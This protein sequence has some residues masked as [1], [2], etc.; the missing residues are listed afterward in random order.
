MGRWMAKKILFNGA[1]GEDIKK[2][3]AV[4]KQMNDL[5]WCNKPAVLEELIK[6]ST[7][8][9]V[10]AQEWLKLKILEKCTGGT[11]ILEFAQQLADE[12]RQVQKLFVTL[13]KLTEAKTK[14]MSGN[15]EFAEKLKELYQRHL[16]LQKISQQWVALVNGLL[17]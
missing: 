15:R 10:Q 2:I 8:S 9:R 7:V 14:S 11:P 1:D 6:L 5:Y 17:L 16:T 13:L 3:Q 4:A 12:D